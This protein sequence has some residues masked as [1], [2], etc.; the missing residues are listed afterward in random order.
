MSHTMKA[1][2]AYTG[3]VLDDGEMDIR[4]LAPALLAF[5]DLVK[6]ANR[7]IGGENEI[8]ITINQDSIQKGSFDLTFMLSTTLLQE[9][10]ALVGMAQHNG[11]ADLLTILGWGVV[12]AESP[13]KIISVFQLIKC[14]KNKVIETTKHVGNG[15][16]KIVL[17]NNEEVTTTEQALRV[18]LDVNC[19]MAIE[20]IIRPV[21]EK[22][23][24][25]GFEIRTPD[26]NDGEPIEKITKEE[27]IM[28]DAPTIEIPNEELKTSERELLVQIISLNFENGKW[29]VTDGNN[30]FWATIQDDN[31]LHKVE[32]RELLFGKGDMLLIS[33]YDHQYVRNGKLSSDTIIT[34][35]KEVRRKLKQLSLPFEEVKE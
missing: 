30:S 13:N 28:F 8:K 11:L 2:I 1:R 4:E 6:Y 20:G 17:K 14:L 25:T 5:A 29:R 3:P 24:I 26:K 22:E 7:E 15:D 32:T 21:K 31:F 16:V 12:C 10:T 34:K 19:R 27:A 18:Y 9:A 33:C 23:G 35:V